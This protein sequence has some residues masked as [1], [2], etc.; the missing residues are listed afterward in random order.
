M[1]TNVKMRTTA[2]NLSGHRRDKVSLMNVILEAS[3]LLSFQIALTD[4]EGGSAKFVLGVIHT[5]I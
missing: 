1:E 5:Y 2:W 4:G 3:A